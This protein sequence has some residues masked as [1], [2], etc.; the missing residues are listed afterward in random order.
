M[1][2]PDVKKNNKKEERRRSR[3]V[4]RRL[5]ASLSGK[6]N[7]N[8]YAQTVDVSSFGFKLMLESGASVAP[9]DCYKISFNEINSVSDV[10][11]VW[12]R[13]SSDCVFVGAEKIF[14][15]KGNISRTRLSELLFNLM[16]RGVSGELRF[17]RGSTI[18]SVFFNMGS[19]VFADS[20]QEFDTFPALLVRAGRISQK[21]F[22]K[23]WAEHMKSPDERME[24]FL[25][26][27]GC[28]NVNDIISANAFRT[29]EIVKGIFGWSEG[30]FEFLE[31][32]LPPVESCKLDI[33]NADL[34]VS[35]IRM[36]SLDRLK[37]ILSSIM[38]IPLSVSTDPLH[39]FQSVTLTEEERAVMKLVD[40]RTSIN[41]IVKKCGFTEE[42]AL[43]ALSVLTGSYLVELGES[44]VE[45]EILEG[46][47][48]IS[49]VAEI[50]A[51]IDKAHFQLNSKNNYEILGVSSSSDYNEIRKA[52]YSMARDFHPDLH[53]RLGKGYESKLNDIFSRI[54]DAHD[55]LSDESRRKKYDEKLEAKRIKSV[56]SSKKGPRY[57]QSAGDLYRWGNIKY[58]KEDFPAAA[59]M[60]RMAVRLEP[61]KALYHFAAGKALSLI[62]KKLKEAEE[63]FLKSIEKDPYNARYLL[64]LGK[65]YLKAR[66]PTR[67]KKIFIET[68]SVDPDNDAARKGIE[69]VNKV[70]AKR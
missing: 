27:F 26:E 33:S 56:L 48:S 15:G 43:S 70:A 38:D 1:S 58:G 7:I 63:C 57:K 61:E 22:D 62:P 37:K 36:T 45:S 41:Q 42:A 35:G 3:R 51:R 20:N 23:V 67:A 54:N 32:Q 52:Y 5:N 4:R 8:L 69:A 11:L 29:K 30:D 12:V 13:Q 28:L 46:G 14:S 18:K 65:L 59:E 19:I 66:L 17:T 16:D 40:G 31:G 21:D 47:E 68:L 34:I 53:H 50:E 60:F 6:N 2:K 10:L 64:E 25:L 9:G 44:I 39:L 49:E 55:L 24:K